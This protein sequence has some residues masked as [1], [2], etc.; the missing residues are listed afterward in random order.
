MEKARLHA[1]VRASGDSPAVGTL[2][3]REQWELQQKEVLK[4]STALAIIIIVII[5]IMIIIIMII[6]ITTVIAENLVGLGMLVVCVLY[7]INP[8][9]RTNTCCGKK[10]PKCHF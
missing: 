3:V 9:P 2:G 8:N 5:I 10:C 7:K 6:I 4:T 1:V